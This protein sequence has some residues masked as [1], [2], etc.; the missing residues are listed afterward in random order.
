LRAGG[1]KVLVAARSKPKTAP[2]DDV[3]IADVSTAAGVT[4]L[5]SVALDRV[6]GID[7]LVHNVGGSAQAD[8]GAVTLTDDDWQSTFDQNLFA[9]VRLDRLLVPGMIE[10]GRGAIVH[11]TSI[12]RR[13]PLPTTLPYAAAKAALANY[14]KALS[15]ELA[16]DGIRVNAVAPGFIETEAA[17]QMVNRI[18]E[19]E[20]IDQG[21]ARARI[22]E[23]IGGIPMGSPGRPRDV[24][25]LV[26]FLVSDRAAYITGAEYVID[27]GS[28]RTV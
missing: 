26:A 25:E 15:N 21:A 24:G 10:R 28:L 18:A 27:G 19:I 9:A 14:S 20:G 4:A 22:V 11:I 16:P 8:G 13:S 7:I 23:S 6:G 1:A 17:A 2:S 12:Q 5:A 3:I